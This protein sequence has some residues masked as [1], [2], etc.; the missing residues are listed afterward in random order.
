MEKLNHR[1][2]CEAGA[3]WLTKVVNWNYR[4]QR[5]VI[6]FC[7]VANENPDLFG[8]RGTK[9]LCV[10]VKVS[11]SDFKADA[12]KKHRTESKGIGATRYYMTPIN[13]ISPDE[14]KNGWG[15]I[16]FDGKAFT[17]AKESEYFSER[18]FYSEL[19]IMESLVR[20]LSGTKKILDFRK[21]KNHE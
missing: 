8:L 17:I 19:A 3:R 11:R 5:V 15:L 21:N 14:I 1:Q 7:S 20:R 6:E 2:L 12:K 16:Y 18:D 13:L 9:N 4:C 10:E